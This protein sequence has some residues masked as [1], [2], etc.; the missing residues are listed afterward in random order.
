[1]ECRAS[2]C[3]RSRTWPGSALLRGFFT[4]VRVPASNLV[5]VEGAASNRRCVS[6]NTSVVASTVGVQSC[7]YRARWSCGPD[8]PLVRQEVAE[9]E[10]R[11]GSPFAGLSRGVWSSPHGVQR[12]DQAVLHRARARVAD[13]YPHLRPETMLAGDISALCYANSYTIMVAPEHPAQHRRR[14][15]PGLPRDPRRGKG[16]RHGLRALRRAG[17]P[18]TYCPG[19]P[20]DSPRRPGSVS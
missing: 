19:L 18:A 12:G 2:R 15:D 8:N 6:S 9:L 16:T 7:L 3:V 5:G 11:T 14:E 10:N 4:D 20:R 17:Q 13:S 1:M